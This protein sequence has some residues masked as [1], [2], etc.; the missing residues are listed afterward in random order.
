M[1]GRAAI[2]QPIC[3][4]CHMRLFISGSGLLLNIPPGYRQ[5]GLMPGIRRSSPQTFAQANREFKEAIL[6]V[7]AY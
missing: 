1:C 5:V 4:Q 2:A 3:R 7:Q 6:L